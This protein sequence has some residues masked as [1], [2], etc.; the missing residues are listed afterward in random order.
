MILGFSLAEGIFGGK[1]EIL[2]ACVGKTKKAIWQ[3]WL[4]PVATLVMGV[5][6]TRRSRLVAVLR[7][8]AWTVAIVA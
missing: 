5:P 3:H 7:E 8:M 1:R 4:I 6:A 2:K